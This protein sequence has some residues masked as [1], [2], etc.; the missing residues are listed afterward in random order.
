MNK[1]ERGG[2]RVE[3]EMVYKRNKTNLQREYTNSGVKKT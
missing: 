3:N 1:R 2:R